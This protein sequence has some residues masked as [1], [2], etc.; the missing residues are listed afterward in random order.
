MMAVPIPDICVKKTSVSRIKFE[1]NRS[2]LIF[3][4]DGRRQYER[5]RIDGCVITSD[6]PRC[7]DLLRCRRDND[8]NS[9][10]ILDYFIELKGS[11]VAH[12]LEQLIATIRRFYGKRHEGIDVQ[13]FAICSAIP[14]ET[15][16]VQRLKKQFFSCAIP[17][18]IEKSPYSHHL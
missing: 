10:V 4:N 17:L 16:R 5:V 2:R 12:A 15:T 6:E 18:H 3:I 7:D 14:R 13:A 9:P 1:E 11:D 8:N